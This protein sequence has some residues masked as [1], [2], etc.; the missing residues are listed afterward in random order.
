MS[1]KVKRGHAFSS[2]SLFMYWL[3][4]LLL[5]PLR[6]IISVYKVKS[7]FS[8]YKNEG[9]EESD[10]ENKYVASFLLFVKEIIVW[11]KRMKLIIVDC[12]GSIQSFLKHLKMSLNEIGLRVKKI[13]HNAMAFGGTRI[14]CHHPITKSESDYPQR[15][16]YL[17][18]SQV[19]RLR[20]R[21]KTWLNQWLNL[22][23]HIGII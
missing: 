14:I 10:H 9:E 2:V 18:W 4:A 1:S 7:A 8:P 20:M 13:C 22:G 19:S 3:E 15:V 11:I 23:L 6:S 16:T 17:I 21:G 5:W 12:T